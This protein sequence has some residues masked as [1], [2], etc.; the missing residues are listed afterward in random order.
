MPVFGSAGVAAGGSG[1]FAEVCAVPA[2]VLAPKPRRASMLEAA[3]IALTGASAVQAIEEHLKLEPGQRILIHG[4]AGGIGSCAIQLAKRIGAQVTTTTTGDGIDFV[5]ALGA[6]HVVDYRTRDFTSLGP[7]FDA[8]LDTIGGDTYARSFTVL[9]RGG[10]IV[11][12]KQPVDLALMDRYQVKAF[13]ELT[14]MATATLERVRRHVDEGVIRARVQRAYA[15]D[16]IRD[17]L[18]DKQAGACTASW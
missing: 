3:A 16:R 11:S 1:A 8:V 7:V 5:R 13:F 15:L 9:R 12:M 6:D 18:R 4:G 17:A 10:A 2:A 14:R